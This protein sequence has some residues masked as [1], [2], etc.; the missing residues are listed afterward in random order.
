[1]MDTIDNLLKETDKFFRNYWSPKNIG[2][3]S[4]W[5]LW[6]FNNSIPYHNKAGCYA[7]I[8][9][10]VVIYIGVAISKGTENYKNHGLGTRLHSYIRLNKNHENPNKYCLADDWKDAANGIMT[11]G[12]EQEDSPLAAALEIYLIRKLQPSR[13]V[14]HRE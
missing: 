10:G 4:R 9:D 2:N 12:F 13:N 7:L 14:Q 1:M 3:P 8:K 5:K 6:D 11:I